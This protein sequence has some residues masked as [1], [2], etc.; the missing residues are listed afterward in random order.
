MPTLH[1]LVEGAIE[2]F[3]DRI[4]SGDAANEDEIYDLIYEVTDSRM[5][6]YNF[7]ILEIAKSS[8]RLA[9]EMPELWP[10]YWVSSPVNLILSNIYEAV[11]D[12]LYN[13]YDENKNA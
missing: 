12:A 3:K 6:V 4:E 2:D 13:R 9:C 7:D 10:A 11:K 1:F 8:L 5:P